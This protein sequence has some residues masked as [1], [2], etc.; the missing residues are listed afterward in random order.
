MYGWDHDFYA[1]PYLWRQDQFSFPHAAF[2]FSIGEIIG[3]SFHFHFLLSFRDRLITKRVQST[4]SLPRL[5][6]KWIWFRLRHQQYHFTL[7][8]TKTFMRNFACMWKM[9]GLLTRLGR[10]THICVCK[11]SVIGSDNS[12]SPPRCQ[13]IIWTNA[14]TPVAGSCQGF[15]SCNVAL[16]LFHLT[17]WII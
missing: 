7:P 16:L 12:L 17:V 13:A 1:N 9:T 8:T 11:L 15:P 10:V 6:F 2:M 14:C 4:S 3:R 5:V